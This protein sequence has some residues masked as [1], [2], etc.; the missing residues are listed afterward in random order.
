MDW[1]DVIRGAKVMHVPSSGR[2]IEATRS[3]LGFGSAL[4]P[5]LAAFR[6]GYCEIYIARRRRIHVR[7]RELFPAGDQDDLYCLR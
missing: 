4:T 1:S 6:L 7:H 2:G 5:A 3:D